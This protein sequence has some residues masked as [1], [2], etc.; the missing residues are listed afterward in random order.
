MPSDFDIPRKVLKFWYK[1]PHMDSLLC[2]TSVLVWIGHLIAPKILIPD[3]MK[4]KVGYNIEE[5]FINK[6]GENYTSKLNTTFN[7]KI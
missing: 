6:L 1:D 7:L 4:Y 2:C 5:T 3:H